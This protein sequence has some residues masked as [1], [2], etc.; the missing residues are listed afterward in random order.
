MNRFGLITYGALALALPACTG[1]DTSDEGGND[2]SST[3]ASGESTD[4]GG[5][6][7]DMTT[8]GASGGL[9]SSG[10]SSQ[11]TDS[12]STASTDDAGSSTAADS[13]TTDGND[14]EL[15]TGTGGTWDDTACGHYMCGIPNPCDALIPGCDCGPTSNFVDGM[16][17]VEDD[18]CAGM[19]AC[20][21]DLEC[22]LVGQ[23]CEVFFPGVKGAPIT[24]T[25][26][27]IPEAC[28]AMPDCQCLEDADAFPPLA[29][30]CM[31]SAAV[32]LTVDI[33]AP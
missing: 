28:A 26:Q 23:Y 13:S 10:S 20:G 30:S 12:G 2:G 18:E 9:D 8:S 5:T 31:G 27:A 1:D 17:C 22:S 19:F 7:L 6:A 15:C 3:A 21:D 29:G 4:D 32:G 33:F 25:C 14:Q 11:G 24:Y 16:G